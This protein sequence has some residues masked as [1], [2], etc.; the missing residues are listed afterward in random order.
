[1]NGFTASVPIRY[2]KKTETNARSRLSSW[3]LSRRSG[4][5]P[6][7]PYPPLRPLPF[8]RI[9]TVTRRVDF[10][11]RQRIMFRVDFYLSQ[12]ARGAKALTAREHQP[13]L[14]AEWLGGGNLCVFVR[15]CSFH[16]G[17]RQI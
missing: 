11:V 13:G 1:M 15:V 16:T 6:A 9:S 4:R 5:T 10:F 2:R 17:L 14:R 3:P 7:L 8:Y 12:Q